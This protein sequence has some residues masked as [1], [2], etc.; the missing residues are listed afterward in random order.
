MLVWRNIYYIIVLVT[1]MLSS[2]NIFVALHHYNAPFE[3]NTDRITTYV[4]V[5]G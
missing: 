4:R 2:K 3:Y 1:L 5:H